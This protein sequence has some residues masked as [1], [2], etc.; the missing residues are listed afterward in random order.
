M[1]PACVAGRDQRIG[2]V[3]DPRSVR[4]WMDPFADEP[5]V[6]IIADTVDPITKEGYG[7]DH[8][9][10]PAGLK[11]SSLH[12]DRRRGEFWSEAEFFVFDNVQF[13]NDHIPPVLRL[14]QM[15]TLNSGRGGDDFGPNLGYRIR[16][17]EATF[18]FRPVLIERLRSEISLTLA[19]AGSTLSA[20]IM[21]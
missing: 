10:W 5:T 11:L 7:M 3:V 14:I 2:H 9:R 20:T 1:L 17:K 18:P 15:R 8:V 21:K 4:Y 19:D 16:A 12:G 13:H 6:C